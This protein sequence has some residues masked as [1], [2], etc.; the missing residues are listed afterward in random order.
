[1]SEEEESGV[2]EDFDPTASASEDLKLGRRKSD[3]K[4]K[5]AKKTK[6]LLPRL[7]RSSSFAL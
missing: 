3:T 7:L 4:K 5:N 6:T 2:D 1:M